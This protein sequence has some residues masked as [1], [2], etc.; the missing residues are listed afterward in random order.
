MTIKNYDIVRSVD[1]L[2]TF[3][4]KMVPE[5]KPIGFDIETGYH[6]PDDDRGA[7]KQETNLLVGFSF[8]NS[9]NWARYVP[10]AHDFSENVL[11][12]LGIAEVLWNAFKSG[13][14][15]AHNAG[16][17]LR[18]M[19]R[20]F[21][22]MLSDHPIFGAEVR[23]SKGYF[24]VRSDTQVEAYIRR[25]TFLIP[26]PKEDRMVE[27]REFALKELVLGTFGHKMIKFEDLFDKLTEK[28]KKAFRFNVLD[29][30]SKVVTY[31]CED[32]LWC[33]S[34]HLRNYPEVKD[35]LVYK[36]D[37]QL[38][39]VICDMED[40]GI[41]Y[42]WNFM[43]ETSAEAKDF[44]AA[45]NEEIQSELA[46]LLDM[47]GTQL[48]VNLGSPKQ[49]GEIL[50]D[51]L[52][53]KVNIYTQGSKNAPQ[54]EKKMSTGKEALD[55]L[56]EKYPIA[57]K[58]NTWRNMTKLT[59]SFLDKYA[60]DYG[61]SP[62]GNIHSSLN[63]SYVRT[64]RFSSAN[65]NQQNQPSVNL[66]DDDGKHES[67][68]DS[69]TCKGCKT[70]LSYDFKLKD[71]SRFKM[72]FRDAVVAPEDCYILGFDLSQ[73]EY[74][75][76]AGEAGETALI[77]AFENGEDIHKKVA[78]M[79]FKI[80][81]SEV[82]KLHR[83]RAKTIGFGLLYGMT[84]KAL[85]KRLNCS[86]E[87][88]EDLFNQYFTAF[89]RI[90]RWTEKQVEFGYK[91]G[92]VTTKFGRVIPVWELKDSRRWIREGGERGCFNYPI[93]GGATGDYLRIAMVRAHKAIA[94]AGWQDK[95]RLF[96]NVHDA[97]EFYV[98]RSL[99]PADVLKVLQP[100]VVFPV[101]GWPTLKADWHVGKRWG[102]VKE[103]ELLEDGK[104]R[105][106][107]GLELSPSKET[108]TYL[109]LDE[110]TVVS[111]QSVP[112]EEDAPTTGDRY[113][114]TLQTLIVELD[115]MPTEEQF[116]NFKKLVNKVQGD[117]SINLATP[118]GELVWW[119]TS[120]ITPEKHGNII[121][122]ALGGARTRWQNPQVDLADLAK[123]IA[124]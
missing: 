86:V 85:A 18:R 100:C 94:K 106:E 79:M 102:S 87:E 63:Q 115:H 54:G 64:A 65:P 73:A 76:V 34:L 55:L 71:G 33:L 9:L 118:E 26:H 27:Y 59:G 98:D 104:I 5:G 29:L 24:P 117:T 36:V 99:N 31:A 95:V 20:F 46:E 17:E 121:S 1:E 68:C 30:T 109:H 58:I 47:P 108:D 53:Y 25:E 105:I 8:T 40:C 44:T 13:L 61:N 70:G 89:P 19:A 72:N 92:F 21:R 28:N 124:F 88:A 90:K 62:D 50:Y 57:K 97:L 3:W 4:D 67:K 32:A 113:L 6:G 43:A 66:K 22:D 2:K 10:M 84:A 93:Q 14:I 39:Q 101:P 69:E 48:N 35:Q 114:P 15:V 16:F 110:E 91:H 12:H 23:S 75:A 111:E 45:L 103:I 74:R 81:V 80:P 83:A 120:G 56:A 123:D 51:K 119:K 41:R 116:E 78:S 37:M 38:I 11:D 122:L 82:S 112:T 96:M 42:D 60:K 52:G 7:L 49:I 77:E 107:D